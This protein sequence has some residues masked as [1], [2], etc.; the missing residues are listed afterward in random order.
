MHAA[1]FG[2]HCIKQHDGAMISF[3]SSQNNWKGGGFEIRGPKRPFG[4][5]NVKSASEFS[6]TV[7]LILSQIYDTGILRSSIILPG[8]YQCL[9]R[10][11]SCAVNE[12]VNVEPISG[13]H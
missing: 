11:L 3:V 12:S 7:L 10:S 2:N 6:T 5:V 13:V 1:Y 9:S 8:R 4:P